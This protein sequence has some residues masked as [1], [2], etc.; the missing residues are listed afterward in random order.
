MQVWHMLHAARWK[1]SR[2]KIAKKSPSAHY[3]TTLSGSIFT[4]KARIVNQR[5]V[6]NINIYPTCPPNMVKFGPP[7]AEIC[8]RVWG[9]PVNFDGFRLLAALLH[10]TL[11][12]GVSHTLR[13]W[14]EGAPKAAITLGIGSHSSCYYYNEFQPRITAISILSILNYLINIDFIL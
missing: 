10:G 3:R 2:Q 7:E 1:F 5:N 4:T 11:V 9:T 14:T 8:W 6:L 12:V 13:R